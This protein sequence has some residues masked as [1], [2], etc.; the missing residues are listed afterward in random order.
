MKNE[1]KETKHDKFKRLAAARVN[2]TL[3][4]IRKLQNCAARSSY[5]Y[6]EANVEAMFGELENALAEC[7]SAFKVEPKKERTLF[8]FMEEEASKDGEEVVP[9]A[10][11]AA[12]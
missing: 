12:E 3:S 6:T 9:M 11:A 10:E 1:V 8:T 2:R 4:E 7:R 5:E